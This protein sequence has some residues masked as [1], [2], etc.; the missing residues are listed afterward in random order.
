[1][2]E[3]GINVSIKCIVTACEHSRA[4][5]EREAGLA[6]G[7]GRLPWEG[8]CLS[9]GLRESTRQRQVRIVVR[10]LQA[11]GKDISWDGA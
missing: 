7:Q 6:S 10:T 2:E 4:V 5:C 3:T 9:R 1:M 11:K 8:D